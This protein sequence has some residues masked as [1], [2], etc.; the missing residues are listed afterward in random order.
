MRSLFTPPDI[1]TLGFVDLVAQRA[2]ARI[3][4]ARGRRPLRTRAVIARLD[5]EILRR[6]ADARDKGDKN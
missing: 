3:A 5:R 2:V 4:L 1:P 6:K